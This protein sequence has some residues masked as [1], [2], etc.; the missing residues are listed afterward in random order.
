MDR[1]RPVIGKLMGHSS[2]W[3]VGGVNPVIGKWG[4]KFINLKSYPQS[5]K[6]TSELARPYHKTPTGISVCTW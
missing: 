6:K 2:H 1:V 5:A 3:E 4:R